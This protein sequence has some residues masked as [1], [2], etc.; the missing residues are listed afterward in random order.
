MSSSSEMPKKKLNF[1]PAVQSFYLLNCLI[2]EEPSNNGG[3]YHFIMDYEID[4]EMLYEKNWCDSVK[5]TDLEF[6]SI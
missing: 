2:L 3:K 5:S 1:V 6:G 4:Y